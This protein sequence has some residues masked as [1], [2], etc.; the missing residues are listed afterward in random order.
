MDE[1][2]SSTIT[3]AREV[4]LVPS[5]RETSPTPKGQTSRSFQ[6]Q[7]RKLRV[8]LSP[9]LS[10]CV[11]A[12]CK[13]IRMDFSIDSLSHVWA[14]SFVSDELDILAFIFMIV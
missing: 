13:G 4:C 2:R 8:A 5:Q 14:L 7:L 10:S 9:L 3:L 6:A 1:F 12:P 11:T